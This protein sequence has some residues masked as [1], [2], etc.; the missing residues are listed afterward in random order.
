MLN[1]FEDYKPIDAAARKIVQEH[2]GN[3]LL[4]S[5]AA[6]AGKTSSLTKRVANRLAGKNS[7]PRCSI[8]QILMVTFTDAAAKEMRSRISLELERESVLAKAAGDR[9]LERHLRRQQALVGQ[10]WIST[11][12]S[13]CLRLVKQNFQIIGIDPRVKLLDDI[14]GKLLRQEC[15]EELLEECYEQAEPEIFRLVEWFCSDK[16]D[17]GLHMAVFDLFEF[18]SNRK[19]R[20]QWLTAAA[21]ELFP[22]NADFGQSIWGMA[23]FAKLVVS[24]NSG[25]ENLG[26]ALELGQACAMEVIPP[27]CAADLLLVEQL[28]AASVRKDYPQMR[29]IAQSFQK[30]AWG[31]TGSAGFTHNGKDAKKD[32]PAYDEIKALYNHMAEDLTKL[33]AELVLEQSALVLRFQKTKLI[34]Q[35]LCALVARFIAKYDSAKNKRACMDFNDLERHC[36]N[37]L[38][39]AAGGSVRKEL[40][41]K[42]CE[43]MTDEYQDTNEVQEEIL[44]LISGGQPKRFMVGDVKQSIYRF[45][46]AEPKIF[47]EKYDHYSSLPGSVNQRVDLSL[48][49]RSRPEVLAS[50]NTVF[51]QIMSKEFGD[52]DYNAAVTLKPGF[53]HYL[54]D[55]PKNAVAAHT[56][57]YLIDKDKDA[58]DVEAVLNKSDADEEE[59]AQKTA[60]EAQI[61]ADRINGLIAECPLIFDKVTTA[62]RELQYRDIAVLLRYNKN[63]GVIANCL[64][65]NGIACFSSIGDGYFLAFEVKIILSLLAV[66]DNPLQDIELAGVL[67]SPLYQFTNDD[68]ANIRLKAEG[69]FWHALLSTAQEDTPLGIRSKAVVEAIAAWRELSKQIQI[70]ELLQAIYDDTQFYDYVAMLQSGDTRQVNLRLLQER[71]IQYEQTNYKGLFRFIN[72]VELLKKRGHDLSEGRAVSENADVVR[73]LS[74]HGSKGLEYPI[75]FLPEMGRGFGGN[76]EGGSLFKLHKTYGIGPKFV[77]VEENIVYNSLAYDFIKKQDRLESLA[78]EL[79][80]LYVAMTRAREKLILVGQTAGNAQLQ[81]KIT[82]KWPKAERTATGTGLTSAGACSAGSWLDWIG[83]VLWSEHNGGIPPSDWEINI[84]RADEIK[85]AQH[86]ATGSEIIK[87]LRQTQPTAAER[88]RVNSLL[89]FSYPRI[90]I[91]L[92]PKITVTELK[93]RTL[94]P[95]DATEELSGRDELSSSR[96]VDGENAGRGAPMCAPGFLGHSS[97]KPD[98]LTVSG[99]LLG[100][101]YHEIFQRLDFQALDYSSEVDRVIA[102]GLQ[103]NVFTAEVVEIIDRGKITDFLRSPLAYRIRKA[104]VVRREQPFVLTLSAA[105]IGIAFGKQYPKDETV[106]LQGIVDVLL[107]ESDGMAVIID[108]KTDNVANTAVLVQRYSTQLHY[109]ALA[110]ERITKR[111]VSEK[112]IWHV[113]TATAVSCQK[114]KMDDK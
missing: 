83:M 60:A 5:A 8:E 34:V 53:S 18:A 88:Q 100:T 16:G 67:R 20:D 14:E 17:A 104:S 2:F 75:V 44:E 24:L 105:E 38:Q 57:V 49:F 22:D 27:K 43:I 52:V 82:E 86:K 51:S 98:G 37:L 31:G 50:V 110:V 64:R 87:Q 33:R 36:L 85:I 61:I 29:S 15:I 103:Q 13:L 76:R 7:Q 55:V 9:L 30:I 45:R 78:E 108:Y 26:R 19:N 1:N 101:V 39:S 113:P 32:K 73:I 79:R 41:D 72:Y 84:I 107:L 21:V 93:R 74:V 80:V 68:L 10:A 28:L 92:A 114:N 54:A 77:D 23:W 102:V 91:E 70:H 99:Q 109:Y 112:I 90:Q 111:V 42:F 69:Y 63:A 40:A 56:E 48:N 96:A 65:N 97:E 81:K 89:E 11:I 25:Q 35:Y 71:A 59:T 58:D 6:G 94:A 62:W 47:T 66:I 3:N 12:H 95:E 46:Q 106:L 4:V